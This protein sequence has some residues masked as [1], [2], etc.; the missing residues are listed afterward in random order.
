MS[1]RSAWS[2]EQPGA[3]VIT[4]RNHHHQAWYFKLSQ[5][6][7]AIPKQGTV[8]ERQGRLVRRSTVSMGACLE[9]CRRGWTASFPGKGSLKGRNSTVFDR[10]FTSPMYLLHW[11]QGSGWVLALQ[12]HEEWAHSVCKC[13]QESRSHP[14]NLLSAEFRIVLPRTL[15]TLTSTSSSREYYFYPLQ[16]MPIPLGTSP[17]STS[18]DS[19]TLFSAPS[20]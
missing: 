14:R 9:A 8:A 18:N 2:T 7:K 15:P 11:Q 3:R 17:N 4:L 1:S 10:G 16:V 5:T 20:T 12:T 6:S 19:I 13:W